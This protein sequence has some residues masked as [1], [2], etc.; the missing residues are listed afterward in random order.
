[1][2]ADGNQYLVTGEDG[3]SR[4]WWVGDQEDYREYHDTEWG[5][6]VDD[7]FRL[8]EKICLEGFQSGLSWLT[9]L[10]RVAQ[11]VW[12]GDQVTR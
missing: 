5:R 1:M 12:L 6:P 2:N 9:I 7:D 4:C 8:F 3:I 10:R 11:P